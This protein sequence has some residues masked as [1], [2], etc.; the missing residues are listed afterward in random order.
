MAFSQSSRLLA[1]YCSHIID[2]TPNLIYHAYIFNSRLSSYCAILYVASMVLPSHA[3][4]HTYA[5]EPGMILVV[6]FTY[7]MS[8]C[9]PLSHHVICMHALL[10]QDYWFLYS[11]TVSLK[12]VSIADCSHVH[13][14]LLL[15]TSRIGNFAIFTASILCYYS[16]LVVVYR[17][18]TRLPVLTNTC[19]TQRLCRP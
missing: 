17:C 13:K 16:C 11:S 8:M 18:L 14:T 3:L 5:S 1:F 7:L 19:C 15:T 6:C 12:L 10:Q 9:T 2:L 4:H